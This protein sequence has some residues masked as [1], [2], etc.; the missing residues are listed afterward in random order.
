VN[1]EKTAVPAA[2]AVNEESLARQHSDLRIKP[3]EAD[4]S[5]DMTD[6]LNHFDLRIKRVEPEKAAGI[7]SPTVEGLIAL[8]T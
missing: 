6:P 2:P 4:E 7:P 8:R 1:E 3:V 5:L